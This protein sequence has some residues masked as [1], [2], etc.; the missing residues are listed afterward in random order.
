MVRLRT[1][2]NAPT[3]GFFTESESVRFVI[4]FVCLGR[5]LPTHHAFN[6]NAAVTGEP[7]PLINTAIDRG[8]GGPS[9]SQTG[10]TIGS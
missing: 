3:K 5:G 10:S 6:S 1:E 2:A 9:I 7:Q 4:R 8:I